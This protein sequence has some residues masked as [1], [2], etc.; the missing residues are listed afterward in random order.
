MAAL[1]RDGV[2]VWRGLKLGVM[3]ELPAAVWIA[4]ELAERCDFF[5]V[6]TNDLIQYTL[7]IDRGNEQVAHLYQPL[8]PGVLRALKHTT[9]AARGRGIPVSVCGEVAADPVLAPVLLGLGFDALSMPGLAIARVRYVLRRM[10]YDDAVRLADQCLEQ[11]RSRDVEELVQETVQ[12]AI[13]EALALL[14]DAAHE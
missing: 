5:S 12:R 9:D 1:E 13:P 4:D 3:I 10:R 14:R 11:G 8:H 2:D 7:G 6:G